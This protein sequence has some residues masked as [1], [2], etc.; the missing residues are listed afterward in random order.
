MPIEDVDY[1][2]SNSIKQTYIFL[3]NS[4]D[5][6]KLIYPNPSNYTIT[7]TVPFNNVVG[8]EVLDA[9][10]PRT[11]YNVDVFNNTISICIYDNSLLS[12][13]NLSVP[14]DPRSIPKQ[15]FKTIQVPIGDYSIQ[16]LIAALNAG[17]QMYNVNN[18][19]PDTILSMHINNDSL[20]QVISI[21][22]KS[23]SNPP[24]INSRI[25]FT[26]PY[27][28]I[29]DMKNSTI[30]ESLGFDTYINQNESEN[31]TPYSF[32]NTIPTNNP[33]AQNYQLY[34]SKDTS[35]NR[36]DGLG[37]ITVPY[38][39][40]SVEDKKSTLPLDTT[41][42]IAQYFE[43]TS[44]GYI[45]DVSAA[46]TSDSY[47]NTVTPIFWYIYKDSD[48]NYSSSYIPRPPSR[49]PS[50]A[51]AIVSGQISMIDA[52]GNIS[53]TIHNSIN[54][55]D[56][57]LSE[58]YYWIIFG[59]ETTPDIIITNP[60]D[61]ISMYYN[62]IQ[63]QNGAVN[64][65]YYGT[66]TTD[67][68]VSYIPKLTGLS[69]SANEYNMACIIITLQ[70]PY[71]T[72]T[73]PGIYSLIGEK[74]LILRCPEI[75]EHSFR[76]LAYTQHYLGVA[77][78]NIGDIAYNQNKSEFNVPLREFHPIGKLPKL[79]LRFETSN[80]SI[81]DFKGVNHNITFAIYYYEAKNQ[82]S[83]KQS[84]LNPNYTGNVLEYMYYEDEQEPESDEEDYDYSRDNLDDYRTVEARHLPDQIRRIDLQNT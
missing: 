15:Y 43:I 74:Y 60:T 3:V 67:G 39:G 56:T 41:N 38:D 44:H 80:G 17:A 40:P 61:V 71:H 45:I 49:I 63:A 6:D 37:Q 82:T 69:S 32:N 36:N 10:I 18:T 29:I 7:F 48:L 52:Y 42:Y 1:L 11:M 16:T 64:S 24:E 25:Q 26:C 70:A 55:H 33:E 23:Y 65:L 27:G 58:G 66:S 57:V 84:V 4:A 14:F 83:F 28:F 62:T 79:T 19:N 30:A 35:P 54:G 77:K 46:F 75:E 68:T 73:S 50:T 47:N 31:Y 78:F 9:S 51:T 13:L 5:R 72:M 76:S 2:K 34:V 12:T 22:A 59:F 81:Y 53:P 8:F 21:T 20:K